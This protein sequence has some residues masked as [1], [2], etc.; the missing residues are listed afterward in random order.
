[1]IVKVL[2]SAAGGGVPQWNC[3]TRLSRL[4]WEGNPRVLGRTQSSIAISADGGR[5]VI[6]DAAPDIREQIAATPELQPHASGP[7]RNSPIAAVI[8]TGGDVDRV[9]GLLSLREQQPFLLYAT[10][11]VHAI[12]DENSIFEVLAR[13]IVERLPLPFGE[14]VAIA[15]T[16]IGVE[17]FPVP[18]KVALYLEDVSKEDFG[19]EAGDTIGLRITAPASSDLV[20]IPG[21]GAVDERVLSHVDG[22][23]CLFF[24]GTVFTDAELPTLGVG[25]KT[26]RRMGHVPIAGMGGSLHAFGTVRLGRRI[27]IHVNTT[28]PILERGSEAEGAVTTAGWDVAYDGMTLTL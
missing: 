15:D 9:A 26:G 13:G 23:G 24:D 2:G 10:P 7:S 5:W 11:R 4:A 12:L 6:I 25:E 17:A 16:G 28:N 20:Y 27:Y 19:T 14:P 3:N 1:M 21:C 18:G 22:A 8:L